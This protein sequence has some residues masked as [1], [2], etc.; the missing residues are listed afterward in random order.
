ME[1]PLAG[2]LNLVNA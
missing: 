1:V 2:A